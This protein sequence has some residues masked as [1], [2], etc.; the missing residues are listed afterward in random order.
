MDM[1]IFKY[2]GFRIVCILWVIF[3]EGGCD[4]VDRRSWLKCCY[5]SF[6]FLFFNFFIE[7]Y[8][9]VM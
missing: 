6:D 1:N 7:D 4:W 9:F 3:V 5:C 2:K 8:V